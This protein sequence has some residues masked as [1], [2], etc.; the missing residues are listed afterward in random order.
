[1]HD[2]LSTLPGLN[3]LCAEPGWLLLK[4]ERYF[5]PCE[6]VVRRIYR[7]LSSAESLFPFF[8]FVDVDRL[9]EAGLP[10]EQIF[11]AREID[12]MAKF[13]DFQEDW[14]SAYQRA[15]GESDREVFKILDEDN[16]VPGCDY[17][18]KWRKK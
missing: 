11:F 16:R 4:R 18:R 12:V 2:Y 6:T 3:G 17:K 14:I 9:V 15:F 5:S 13:I 7:V 1:M 8:V 10:S